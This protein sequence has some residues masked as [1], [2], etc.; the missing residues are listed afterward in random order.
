MAGT[1]GILRIGQVS[2]DEMTT[3]PIRLGISRCLLGDDVR[4]DGGH[5]R[6][7]FLTDILS[8]YVEWVPVCPEVE[9]GLGT[10]REA[11]RLVGNPRRPRLMTITSKQD[12]TDAMATMIEER[13]ESLDKL[14]LSGFVFKKGSPSC[15]I[16]RVRVYTEKGIPSHSRSGIFA[17]ACIEKFPLL[18]VEDE[19]RLHDSAQRENFIERVFCYRRFQ[20]LMQEGVTRQ[21]LIGFHTTHKYLLLSHSQQHYEAM[22]RL[23]GQADRYRLKELTT[24]YGELFMRTLALKATVR[25]HVNVLHH[26]VGYFKTRLK[27]LEKAELLGVID[28]YHRGL[29]PLIVPLTLIKHYVRVFDVDYIRDQ[30]YLNPHPKELMLRNHV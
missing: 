9:A 21:A 3:S 29:T 17:H 19:G 27:T 2:G 26:I 6:D 14:N 12:H 28:D 4:F 15:G 16:E 20:D 1:S 10:P 22:S 8:R 23:V 30:V 11:M 18:P 7:H 5:K 25:K 13:L 24:K